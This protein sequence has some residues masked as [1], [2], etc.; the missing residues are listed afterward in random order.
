MSLKRY[1]EVII[2]PLID[3]NPIALQILGICSALA[4]TNSLTVTLVMCIALTTVVS[5]SNL[6]ISCQTRQIDLD[7]F[8][9]YENQAFPSS[10]SSDGEL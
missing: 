5:F 10:I 4:V 3:E 2:R 1:Q 9:K 6:F 7:D 8:Y